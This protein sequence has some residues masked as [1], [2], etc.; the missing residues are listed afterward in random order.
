MLQSFKEKSTERDWL[1]LHAAS[2]LWIEP[3]QEVIKKMG[4]YFCRNTMPSHN[5]RL[6][7]NRKE[8]KQVKAWNRAELDRR[9]RIWIQNKATCFNVLEKHKPFKDCD[10]PF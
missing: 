4:F 5:S 2:R 7:R 9:S 8:A 1:A 6:I 10:Y 3:K